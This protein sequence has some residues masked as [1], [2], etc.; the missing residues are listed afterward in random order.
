MQDQQLVES[1]STIEA[2]S[3][4][5]LKD[6]TTKVSGMSLSQ[7]NEGI[8]KR[9]INESRTKEDTV[10]LEKMHQSLPW[11]NGRG[12]NCEGFSESI[13]CISESN[14]SWGDFESFS[15]SLVKSEIISHAPEVLVN[16][17]ET[18]TSKTGMELYGE[19]CNTSH[20]HHC[21]KP[22]VHNGREASA[23]SQDKANL[24]YEDIFKLSFPEVIVP[25]STESIRS[26]DQVLDRDNE[27]IGIPEFTKRQLC[28]DPGN[29]WRT[30]RDPDS[31]TGLRCPWNKSHCQENF[32][33]ALGIDVNQKD[34][35][36][37][38]KDGLEETNI[39]INEDLEDGF[40]ISNCKALIQTKLAVSP[41]SRHGHFFSYNLFLKRTPSNGN[42]QF[43]TVPGKKRIFS[44]HSLKMK[45][46]NSDVC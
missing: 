5:S 25:Q 45:I 11:E 46:F 34:F 24:I 21:S 14:S 28:I 27:D 41:D 31:T 15:E 16:S 26:L 29:L 43:K 7:N 42:M 20:R 30:L 1:P 38:S 12:R 8:D 10:E 37:D 32:L 23:S 35:S 17:S 36:G 33:S 18:K 13:H 6:L 39:K 44:T 40:N 19:Y 9:N 3:W 22:S 4:T 2:L